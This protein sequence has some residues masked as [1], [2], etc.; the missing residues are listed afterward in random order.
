MIY[1]NRGMSCGHSLIFSEYY[2][3]SIATKCCI[4]AIVGNY[5]WYFVRAHKERTPWSR[6]R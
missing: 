3:L 4:M 2:L 6:Q 5:T 1:K